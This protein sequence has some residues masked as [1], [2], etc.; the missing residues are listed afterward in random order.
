MKKL[1]DYK[2][3]EA[4]DLLVDILEPCVEI[5]SDKEAV[6]LLYSKDKKT[7]GVKKLI[8]DHKKA[9]MELLAAMEGVPVDQFECSIYTLPVRL[10][11]ILNDKELLAFFTAQQSEDSSGVF[12]SAMENTGDESH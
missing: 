8:K 6:A 7:D 2:G 11:E 4:L 3:E 1:S 10:L 12:G 9:V 5:M